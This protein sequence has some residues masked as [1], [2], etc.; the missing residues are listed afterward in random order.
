M[1]HDASFRCGLDGK[2]DGPALGDWQ[3]WARLYAEALIRF[4]DENGEIRDAGGLVAFRLGDE[5][6]WTIVVHPLWDTESLPGILGDAWAALDGPKVKRVFSNTF[7]LARRQ[8]KER[9]R[10]VSRETWRNA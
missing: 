10:L 2:F 4:D 9:Q 7:E 8:I 1:V 3:K 5:P 6:H